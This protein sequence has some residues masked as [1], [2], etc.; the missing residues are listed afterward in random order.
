MDLARNEGKNVK[1]M[2]SIKDELERIVK[3]RRENKRYECGTTRNRSELG[4]P[5]M[6]RSSKAKIIV[7]GVSKP[8]ITIQSLR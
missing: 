6:P 3:M 1:K 5:L 2:L 7:S 8:T 4:H